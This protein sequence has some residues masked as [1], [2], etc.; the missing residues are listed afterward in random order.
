MKNINWPDHIL[1][2]VAV[3]LGV[4]LAFQVGELAD[5]NKEK[6]EQI[7]DL[8]SFIKDLKNDQQT[9]N[10]YQIPTNTTQSEM[11]E[12]LLFSILNHQVDSIENQLSVSFEVNNYSPISSTYLSVVS[13]GKLGL[14]NGL[15][16]KKKISDYYDVL[17]QESVKKGEIQVDFFLKE[18]IPWMIDNTNM[19]DVSDEELSGD[20][21]LSNRLLIYKSLIDSKTE[22]Y[23]IMAKASEKLEAILLELK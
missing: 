11:I 1:N 9:F 22:H 17:A 7:V 20:V 23:K 5:N 18:M 12:K 10:E 2:F 21:K 6:Q 15:E 8:D 4:F 19:L 13:S 16:A 14:I 3:I